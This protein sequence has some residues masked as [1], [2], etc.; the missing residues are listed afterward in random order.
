LRLSRRS[1]SRLPEDARGGF[2]SSPSRGVF[3]RDLKPFQDCLP[4]VLEGESEQLI[5]L[6]LYLFVVHINL[7]GRFTAQK[8][9]KNL[10]LFVVQTF[11]YDKSRRRL[12]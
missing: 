6:A 10:G 2:F 5:Q 9:V 1:G 7:S 8:K 12:A 11:S 4:L 3:H